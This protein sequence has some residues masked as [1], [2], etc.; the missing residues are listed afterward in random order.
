MTPPRITDNPINLWAIVDADGEYTQDDIMGVGVDERD[1][2]M[3]FDEEL[4]Y[5]PPATEQIEKFKAAG[6]RAVRLACT[7]VDDP[8]SA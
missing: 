8:P 7:V 3:S 6:Y 2:W 1:A 5:G 4:G